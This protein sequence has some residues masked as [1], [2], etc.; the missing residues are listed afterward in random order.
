MDVSFSLIINIKK[1]TQTNKI[2]LQ[3]QLELRVPSQQVVRPLVQP[4]TP[5]YQEQQPRFLTI[6]M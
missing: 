5:L 4:H 1:L 3:R 2:Y 6:I